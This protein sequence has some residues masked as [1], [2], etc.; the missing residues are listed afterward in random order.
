[1]NS[2]LIAGVEIHADSIFEALEAYDE[3]FEIMEEQPC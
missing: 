2:Y 3:R 1:M